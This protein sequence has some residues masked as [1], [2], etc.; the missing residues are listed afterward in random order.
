MNDPDG[1]ENTLVRPVSSSGKLMTSPSQLLEAP[2]TRYPIRRRLSALVPA[3]PSA[4]RPRPRARA[5]PVR[6]ARGER[7]CA[8]A[9]T[10]PEQG[11]QAW[12]EDQGRWARF[13]PTGGSL[14][15]RCW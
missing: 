3:T 10:P 8:V 12:L 13:D 15:P 5:S 7:C 6:R 4:V 11:L 14:P 1:V 2:A 9:A